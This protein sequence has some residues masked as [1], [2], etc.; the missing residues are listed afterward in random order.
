MMPHRRPILLTGSHRSGST[1]VGLVMAAAPG[2]GYVDE[3]MNLS[4]W[5][6]PGR[7]DL[8]GICAARFETW[9]PYITEANARPYA[10]AL[11]RTIEFGFH[12]PGALRA[13]RSP[14][15]PFRIAKAY[16]RCA[17]NAAAGRRA[18][19]KDPLAVLSAPWLARRFDMEV[20]VLVRHP[21]AF[22]DSIKRRNWHFPFAHLLDQPLL[23]EKPLAS[24]R[25]EIE[26]FARH[27]R[28][29]VD[30][31]ALL[32]RII[33]GVAVQYRRDH[34]D[35]V[36][37][38]HED[39]SRNPEAEFEKLFG[40]LGLEWTDR[41]RRTI[42]RYSSPDFAAAGG[43]SVAAR[44]N[45]DDHADHGDDIDDVDDADHVDPM[46]RD[47]RANIARWK[48]SLQPEEIRRVRDLT[49]DVWTEF[50]EPEDW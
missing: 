32:W 24:V 7:A 6:Q 19:V 4:H 5:A 15:D 46:R 12:W 43:P 25:A 1:W 9:F 50:Y 14:K 37:V 29:I 30:Q 2:V 31:A 34:P 3:P 13:I 42:D 45:H 48:D 16:A 41:V 44:G 28:D 39:L 33:Y 8:A 38:R 26:S 21:A 10:P 27:E 23:M 36:F 17:A 47:S 40:R 35:W 20:V 22:A 18:L 49:Q 11:Q